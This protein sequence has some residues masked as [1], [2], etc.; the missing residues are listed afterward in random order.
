MLSLSI[1]PIG[2]YSEKSERIL[3]IDATYHVCLKR[4]WFASF[5]KLDEGLVSFD[6][7]HTCQIEG[8]CTVRIK[9]FDAMISELK[10][11]K[12]YLS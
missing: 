9:L 7:G 6:D 5:E 2:C 11:M 12:M 10:D 4:E 8:I 3:D 1:T